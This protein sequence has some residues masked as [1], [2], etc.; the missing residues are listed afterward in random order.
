MKTMIAGFDWDEGNWPK[1]GKHG[2]S[3]EE[4]ELVFRDELVAMPDP[5]PD[6]PRMRAIGKTPSGRYLFV[7]FMLRAHDGQTFI[8]PVSA[9][10]MHKKEIEHYES[11]QPKANAVTKKRCPS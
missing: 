8:R 6:E 7:V 4:I 10:Y 11:L 1:C 5:H 3:K 9:R 2:V